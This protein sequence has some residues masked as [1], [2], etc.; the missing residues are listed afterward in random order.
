MKILH[1]A[2]FGSTSL[3]TGTGIYKVVT[4]LCEGQNR[5]GHTSRIFLINENKVAAKGENISLATSFSTFKALLKGFGPEI[6][7]F[8]SLHKP[9]YLRIYRELKRRGIPYCI[10]FHGAASYENAQKGKYKKLIANY[11]GFNKFIKD[12]ASV[13]YLNK[14]EQ[15]DSIFHRLNPKYMII[16]NGIHPLKEGSIAKPEEGKLH[17]LYLGRIDE[18]HKGLDVLTKA[19][20]ILEKEGWSEKIHFDFYGVEDNPGNFPEEIKRH[21]Q[22]ATFHGPVFG[23]AKNEVYA[24]SHIYILT[25]RYEGMPLTIFEALAYGCPCIVTPYTNCGEFL[26]EERC[27]WLT[28]LDPEQIAMAVKDAY[29]EYRQTGPELVKEAMRASRIY[30]W[31]EIVQE[32]IRQYGAIVAADARTV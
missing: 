21:Q 16:P 1:L 14:Q 27:G 2:D 11:L 12:A 32:T 28:E 23:E 5:A 30:D 24:R 10:E 6:V 18:N 22:I 15:E 8:H 25:S 7:I 9:I 26:T 20:G 17:I 29:N 31:D 13:I 4:T 19:I 3:G